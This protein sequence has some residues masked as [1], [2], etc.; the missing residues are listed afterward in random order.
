VSKIERY[1]DL[2]ELPKWNGEGSGRT[3]TINWEKS[4]G[5]E[6]K[7]IYDDIEFS[8]KIKDYN[9]KTKNL[10]IIYD[11]NKYSIKTDKFKQCKLNNIL[12]KITSNFK[13]EIGTRFKNDKR[14]IT[15]IAC[16][17]IQAKNGQWCKYYKYTCNKCGFDGGKHWNIKDREYKD[18]HWIIESNLLKGTGCSCCCNSPQ[19]VVQ[20]INDIITTDKWMIPYIGEECAKIHNHSSN[21]KVQVICPDCGRTKD[22]EVSINNIFNHRGFK[23]VCSDKISYPNKFAYE[24]LNQLNQIYGFNHIEHEYSPDWISLK[25]YDNYFIYNG[26]EY[27]LEMDGGLGH[28]KKMHNKTKLTMDDSIRID[29]YKDEQA[30]LHEIEVIRID[31]DYSNTNAFTYIRNNILNKKEL[32]ILFDLSQIDF[33]K[34]DRFALHNFVKI[35]CNYKKNNPELTCVKISKIMGHSPTTIQTWLIKGTKQ[36]W[37]NYNIKEEIDKANKNNGIKAR[38]RCSIPIEILKD[39]VLLGEFPSASYLDEHSLELFGLKLCHSNISTV[40]IGKRKTYQ[41]FTFRHKK[42]VMI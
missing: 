21:E 30:K 4:V 22:K 20:G 26:K 40:C 16:I 41:G 33:L 1:I 3:G 39:D 11:E 38:K 25:R 5:Y 23:C 8:I 17:K 18:E 15:I 29:D 9:K 36:G 35:A 27:I 2:S 7:G 10:L 19:I 37:C 13:I 24:L 32:N 6:V 14:D 42:E 12:G 34:C 31:C 28:G